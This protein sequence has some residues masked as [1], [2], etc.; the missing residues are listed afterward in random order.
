MK[1][2]TLAKIF[3]ISAAGVIAVSAALA[4]TTTTVTT[5]AGAVT[6]GL[7]TRTGSFVTYTPG[8]EYFTFRTTPAAEPVRYYYTKETTFVD[9]TGRTV[10]LS[11]IRPIGYVRLVLPCF[12]EL[13][14]VAV[15]GELWRVAVCGFTCCQTSLASTCRCAP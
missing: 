7:T 14:R 12:S 4:Q 13:W 8:D 6:T 9:P 10:E 3:A 11:A 15:C 2:N 5:D 1:D